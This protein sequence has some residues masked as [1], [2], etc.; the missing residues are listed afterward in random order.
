MNI[1]EKLVHQIAGTI[2]DLDNEV[3]QRPLMVHIF[4]WSASMVSIA[5]GSM[6]DLDKT[7]LAHRGD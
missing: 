7:Q 1:E 3:H 4:I 6:L 2:V 5:Q